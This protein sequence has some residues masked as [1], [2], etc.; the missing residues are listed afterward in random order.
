MGEASSV[1]DKVEFELD[2]AISARKKVSGCA[3]RICA[4]GMKPAGRIF[5]VLC[6]VLAAGCAGVT[7]APP[8]TAAETGLPAAPGAVLSSAPEP[9]WPNE[10]EEASVALPQYPLPQPP[11]DL[12]P[13]GMN[14][15]EAVDIA[16][17][18][19]VPVPLQLPQPAA[20]G[21]N[22]AATIS[23]PAHAPARIVPAPAAVA[24][25]QL[26][27]SPSPVAKKPEPAL[28]VASLKARLRDTKAIGVFTKLALSNQVDDV[29]QQFR[30]HY[31]GG[32][33][34]S[35]AALR[36]PF[37]TL[38]LKVLALIQNDDPSLART[39]SASREAIWNILADP[40]K[41]HA[42]S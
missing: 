39:I 20:A 18:T 27:E 10:K 13:K 12:S 40:E 11:V 22:T 15:G 6:L 14:E 3:L 8:V 31:L 26:K 24:Q 19:A 29:M 32:Q 17:T 21:P 38:V 37:D 30:A 7:G 25:P 33:K 2:D 9:I 23:P 34:T 42:A 41:F 16:P 1:Q 4:E 28:D 35:V 36:Q 5:G